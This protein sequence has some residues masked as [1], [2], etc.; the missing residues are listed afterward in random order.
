MS[1]RDLMPQGM[2]IPGGCVGNTLSKVKGKGDGVK[3][4]AR[5]DNMCNVKHI[6]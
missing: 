1:Y 3:N 6:E 5:G 4:S 2:G